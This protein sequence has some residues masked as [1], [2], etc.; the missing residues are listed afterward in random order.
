MKGGTHTTADNRTVDEDE[1]TEMLR[2]RSEAKAKKK[3]AEADKIAKALQEQGICY[4]D[5]QRVWYTKKPRAEEAP[6]AEDAQGKDKG[7]RKRED[8]AM[9]DTP[10]AEA[11]PAAGGSAKKKKKTAAKTNAKK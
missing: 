1:V 10:D 2:R 5:E 8:D 6:K 7:K 3:Y 11:A 4:I 9:D